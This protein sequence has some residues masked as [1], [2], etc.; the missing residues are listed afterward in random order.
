MNFI[1]HLF[2]NIV[3]FLEFINRKNI[4]R[5]KGKGDDRLSIGEKKREKNVRGRCETSE[6][7]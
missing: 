4:D 3:S 7:R 1:L 6:N 5:S 2:F